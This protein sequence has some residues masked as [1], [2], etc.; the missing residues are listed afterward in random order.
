MEW[1]RY[2]E[3]LES[4]QEEKE[5]KNYEDENHGEQSIETKEDLIKKIEETLNSYDV[6]K[7]MADAGFDVKEAVKGVRENI[8]KRVREGKEKGLISEQEG[9][10]YLETVGIEI[11]KQNKREED[12]E[13]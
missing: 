12:N 2:L 6:L 9:N 8:Q 13:R 11:V 7:G 1:E 5:E 3:D 10:Q 4:S